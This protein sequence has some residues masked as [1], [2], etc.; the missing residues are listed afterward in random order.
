MHKI[1]TLFLSWD[2][3]KSSLVVLRCS[4]AQSRGCCRANVVILHDKN[5]VLILCIILVAV[6]FFGQG[7]ILC[8]SWKEL[9]DFLTWPSSPGCL[10][11]TCLSWTVSCKYHPSVR[12]GC[13][14]DR[15]CICQQPTGTCKNHPNFQQDYQ[16]TYL[17]IKG[18]PGTGLN[19]PIELSFLSLKSVF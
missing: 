18:W 15:K 19:I 16:R 6:F 14:G 4:D 7:S 3:K 13:E 10:T 1:R 8:M 12:L 2:I 11:V 17:L 5:S 9:I